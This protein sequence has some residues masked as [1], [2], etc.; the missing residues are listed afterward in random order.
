[1]NMRTG[2]T[3]NGFCAAA[4]CCV[5][6]AVLNLPDRADAQDQSKATAQPKSDATKASPAQTGSPQDPC[7]DVKTQ[8]VQRD[9]GTKAGATKSDP[10]IFRM[11]GRPP[12][13]TV[14]SEESGKTDLKQN[15]AARA[16]A[17]ATDPAA[18]PAAKGDPRQDK[19]AALAPGT[20]KGPNGA[21][22]KPDPKQPDPCK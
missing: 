20:E 12:P 1:M 6:V 7:K 4:L 13:P 19:V 17:A 8:A 22:A 16:A 10:F 14:S 11:V 9:A 18:A 15:D 2:P 21:P 5:A 3:S